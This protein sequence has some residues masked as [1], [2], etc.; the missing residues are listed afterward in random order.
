[1]ARAK[2]LIAISNGWALRNFVH[3]N[4]IN[5]LS[6]KYDISIAVSLHLSGYFLSLKEEGVISSVRDLPDN[7]N[8]FW[9]RIRQVKKMLLHPI[10]R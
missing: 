6:E 4:L 2:V 1:M 3:T 8:F 5:R 10:I 9:R 7:E